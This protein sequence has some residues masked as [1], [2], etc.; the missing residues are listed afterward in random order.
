LSP[1]EKKVEYAGD[2]QTLKFYPVPSRHEKDIEPELKSVFYSIE[3]AKLWQKQ[4]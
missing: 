2:D 4:D 1:P 3:T